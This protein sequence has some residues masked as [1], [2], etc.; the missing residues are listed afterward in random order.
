MFGFKKKESAFQK[1]TVPLGRSEPK[2][3]KPTDKELQQLR[4]GSRMSRK[5]HNYARPTLAQKI[6]KKIDMANKKVAD[7]DSVMD[8]IGNIGGGGRSRLSEDIGFGSSKK[9]RSSANFGAG[10]VS[11]PGVLKD[12]WGKL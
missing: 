10:D 3:L 5:P 7:F 6:N 12:P 1:K 2:Y 9:K 8:N 4:G 11:M